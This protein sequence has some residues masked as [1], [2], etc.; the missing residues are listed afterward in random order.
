[1]LGIETGRYSTEAKVKSHDSLETWKWVLRSATRGK[2]RF[3]ILGSYFDFL[4][5]LVFLHLKLFKTLWN[6]VCFCHRGPRI[7]ICRNV[8][9]DPWRSE[10]ENV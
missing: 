9:G 8:D 4:V 2:E 1:M 3:I 7:V 5:I 6:N 10:P